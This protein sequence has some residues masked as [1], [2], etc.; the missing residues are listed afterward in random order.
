M[1]KETVRR[2]NAQAAVDLSL[3]KAL[4]AHQNGQRDEALTYYAKVLEAQPSHG[5]ALANLASLYSRQG[6]Y[7]EALAYY[8]KALQ[9]E[10]AS[11]E[12]WFNYGNLQQR[13]GLID[14]AIQSFNSALHINPNLYHAHYNLAHLYRDQHQPDEAIHHYQATITLH[15]TFAAAYR[16][17]GRLLQTCHRPD[18][19]HALYRE[20]LARF[21]EHVELLRYYGDWLYYQ[22]EAAAALTLYHRVRVLQPE[23]AAIYN[24]LGVAYRAVGNFVEAERA[25]RL[26]LAKD[27]QQVEALTNM[28]TL[29]RL[30]KR[31]E[32]A[33]FFLRKA[34]AVRPQDA[35]SVA[36][37]A[38]A[39]IDLGSISEAL[40]LIDPLLTHHPDHVDLLAMKAFAWVQQAR[41]DASQELLAKARQLKPD[42]LVAIGNTLF[43]SLYR[44]SLDAKAQSDFHR[45]LAQDLC[46]HVPSLPPQPSVEITGWPRNRP[47]LREGEGE[48]TFKNNERIFLPPP[49]RGRNEQLRRP[50][51]IGYLSP[52]FRTHPIGYFIEP[53]LTHHRPERCHSTCY[54][55]PCAQDDVT[56]RLKKQAH[57]WRD[58]AGWNMQQIVEKIREDNMDIL[59]DL[60]GYTAGGRM[61]VMASRAAPVQAIFLG[62]PY[63][64]GLPN[65]D[66]ILADPHIIPADQEGLYSESVARLDH[67][68]LCY[69]PQPGTPE[70]AELP[71]LRNGKIT[72]GSYNNL[73]KLSAT[74][75]DLWAQVLK[76]VPNSQL[77]LM[78]SSLADEGTRLLFHQH[79]QERGIAIERIVLLPPVTPL[80][81]FLAEYGRL[82][83]ALDPIP[84]NGGTTSCEA[85]WMGVPL[86]TLAGEGFMS[87]M[88]VSLLQTIHHPEWVANTPTEYVR[89]A[90]NLARDLSG[91]KEIRASLRTQIM[92]S[93]LYDAAGYAK[94]ME[95]LYRQMVS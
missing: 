75:L 64:T 58:C 11:A 19:V 62:Y 35:D 76:A 8:Q 84:F 7:P 65:M 21:P 82:D 95:R 53:L 16:H 44:D 23:Q 91:L 48:K 80:S 68:F 39:L 2:S 54:A 49:S 63:T 71:A 78:A 90:K 38:C 50:L 87:R 25:W 59:V 12:L 66:F 93:A 41:I 15:P 22:E 5:T 73:P 85:L 1:N 3:Q 10:K 86:V 34:V 43:S 52:D 4:Q 83:I 9:T 30:Q 55:L 45:Q 94:N 6:H 51:R 33:L 60:A 28:G 61:D 18:A 70:V 89:I 67:C 17:L 72:F 27:P 92:G 77:V 47:I 74:C 42:S 13:L 46:R 14:A 81:R 20:A 57:Q 31:H 40:A 56:Q 32:E 36:S 88:G 29:C 26:C 24:A 37:L 69:Q 79:F